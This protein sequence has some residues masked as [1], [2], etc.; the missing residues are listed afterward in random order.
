MIDHLDF[1]IRSIFLDK[2]MIE[3][4]GYEEETSFFD[5]KEY[6]IYPFEKEKLKL[7]KCFTSSCF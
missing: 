6:E 3:T 4:Y 5:Q 7:K 1:E 2:E